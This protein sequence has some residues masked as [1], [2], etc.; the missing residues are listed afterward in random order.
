MSARREGGPEIVIAEQRVGRATH[1]YAVVGIGAD[2]AEYAEYALHEQRRL[3]QFAV[4]EIG[5][6]IQMSDVVAFVL[7][8]GAKVG[9]DFVNARHVSERVA[10]DEARAVLDVLL[11]PRKLPF[12]DLAAHQME[13][14]V[15]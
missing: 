10:E 4:E 7:V 1:E 3:R 14:E 6:I 11:L 8:A 15:H 5:E 2:P 9:H 12:L 13:R